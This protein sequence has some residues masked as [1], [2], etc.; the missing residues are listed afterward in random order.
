MSAKAYAPNPI[1]AY[2]PLIINAAITG[3]V[4]TRDRVPHVP[5]T[6]DQI[7]REAVRCAEAGASIVHLHARDADERPTWR[8]EVYAEFI[9]RIRE[10]V[11]DL[12]I[13]VTT[14]GRNYPEVEKRGEALTLEGDAKPDMASLTLSS[15]NFITGPSVNA[16]ETIQALAERMRDRGIRPELEVFD[17]GMAYVAEHLA[18]RGVL[19]PPFYANLMMGSLGTA[20][21]RMGDLAHIVS[22]L[23][24]GTTWAAAGL[25]GTQLPMNAMAVFAG[26]HVRTGLEDNPYLDY[27]ARTPATN[28]ALVRRVAEMA[29]L[30]GRPVATPAQVRERLGLRPAPSRPF[31]LRPA[32][33]PDDRAAALAV[34]ETANMHHVPSAE[35]HDL[36]VGDWHVAEVGGRVVGVCGFDLIQNGSGRIGKTTLMAVHPDARG[37][38]VGIALQEL[39]MG[40]MRDAGAT[41]VVTNAD[42]PETIEWYERHFGYRRVGE[43]AKLHEFGRPDVDRWTTL[44]APLE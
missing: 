37:L 10:R 44:E 27:A 28:P 34:L 31:S 43:V 19:E 14:S 15:L 20:P 11:P 8:K 29:A 35:M 38:G 36:D 23:P 1:R 32:R 9:P 16:P 33:L 12:V 30:A 40:L 2:D 18:D 17:A 3:M 21:A 7:V 26:G 4:P 22:S 13:C 5:V 39:R 25:G 41:K 6:P 42:R 24:Q